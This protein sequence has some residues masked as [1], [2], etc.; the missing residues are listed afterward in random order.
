MKRHHLLPLLAALFLTA[1]GPS[2]SE[3]RTELR[4]ID[5]EL[6]AI[7]IAANQYQSQMSQAEFDAFWGS[8]AAG[9]GATT[10]DYG[11]A[12]EGLSAATSAA[13]QYDLSAYSLDQL[14]ARY[15]ILA[16]RRAEI[17]ATLD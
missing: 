1:C 7:Q 10:G 17:L 9:F 13:H 6:V 16:K 5:T 11:L 2:E 3:L 12:G 14:Q 8:F 4:Q 15:A